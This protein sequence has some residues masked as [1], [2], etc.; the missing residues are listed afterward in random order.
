MP[1]SIP[2]IVGIGVAGLILMS[3]MMR[4]LA[5]ATGERNRSPYAAAVETRLSSRLL[6][7]VRVVDEP[8]DGR[9]TRVVHARVMAGFDMR[10]LADQAGLEL[11]LGSIRAGDAPERVR[12]VLTDDAEP[13]VTE[14]F[15]VKPPAKRR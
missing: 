11:W 12:V 15:D 9:L 10:K 13:P 4:H 7:R 2:S 6:G 14:S 1:K 3:L 5:E 8:V